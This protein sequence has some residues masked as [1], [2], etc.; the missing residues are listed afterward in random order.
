MKNDGPS[1]TEPVT[2]RLVPQCLNQLRYRGSHAVQF[3]AAYIEATEREPMDGGVN[4][5]Q[6]SD[7]LTSCY[8][9]L[10]STS[11]KRLSLSKVVATN[12]HVNRMARWME[13]NIGKHGSGERKS[14]WGCK[15]GS[16]QGMVLWP[17]YSRNS[18][19]LRH[20]DR[21]ITGKNKSFLFTNWC[22]SEL[23]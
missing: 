5:S 14:W 1:G 7:S 12:I 22:T 13:G 20:R 23:P 18:S 10:R 21:E 4:S 6:A 11:L 9:C 17:Q 15:G 2:Y 8:L 19:S 16:N 3:R